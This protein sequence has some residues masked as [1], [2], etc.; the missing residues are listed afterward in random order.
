M[1]KSFRSRTP[2]CHAGNLG[3]TPSFRSRWVCSLMAE[4]AALT[5]RGE[6]S[7]PSRPTKQ[8]RQTF[9][10]AH[11]TVDER[12]SCPGSRFRD[13]QEIGLKGSLRFW[14]PDSG[15]V[16]FLH[17]LPVRSVASALQEGYIVGLSSNGRTLG[18]H[19]RNVGSSPTGIHQ[20]RDSSRAWIV[21]PAGLDTVSNTVGASPPGVRVP[22]YPPYQGCMGRTIWSGQLPGRQHRLEIG[23]HVNVFGSVPSHSANMECEPAGAQARFA[24]PL[25]LRVRSSILPH[26][27]KPATAQASLGRGGP[28]QLANDHITGA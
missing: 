10:D 4:Q 5:R 24:K 14:K 26:S 25:R 2:A 6:G 11:P 9:G 8:A 22:R 1:R 18:L 7:I 13:A 19:S 27:A 15:Q 17:L 3:A 21:H 20:P 23:W 12:S 16:R 28:P